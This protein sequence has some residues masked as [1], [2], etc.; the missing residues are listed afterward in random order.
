MTTENTL[1]GQATDDQ[2]RTWKEEHRAGIY[3]IASATD[4]AYF[5]I[6]TRHDVAKAQSL[7]SDEKPFAAITEFGRLCFI[8]GSENVLGDD[9]QFLAAKAELAKRW[10]G[11]KVLSGNL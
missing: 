9:Q 4:I 8:G 5:R 10:S 3:F 2:I 6:P 1:K 7:A 11:V